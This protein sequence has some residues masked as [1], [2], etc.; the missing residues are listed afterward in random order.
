MSDPQVAIYFLP[1]IRSELSLSSD[2]KPYAHSS[3]LQAIRLYNRLL[4][5]STYVLLYGYAFALV[6]TWLCSVGSHIP[7]LVAVDEHISYPRHMV[8]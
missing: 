6:M 2:V 8:G 3:H 5:P 4:A 1:C 7:D